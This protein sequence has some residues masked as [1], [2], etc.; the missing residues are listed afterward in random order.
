MGNIYSKWENIAHF[1]FVWEKA[2]SPLD[3]EWLKQ[4]LG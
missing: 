3:L 1:S 4:R 2:F